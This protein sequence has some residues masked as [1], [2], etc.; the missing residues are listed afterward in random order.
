MPT[1]DDNRVL[2]TGGARGIGA[3]IAQR[4][5]DDGYTPVILDRYGDDPEIVHCDLSGTASTADALRRV[6]VDGPITRIVNN[7]GA[8]FPHTLEEQTLDEFDRAAALNLRSAFQ[9]TQALIPGMT[10]RNFGRIVSVSSRAALGKTART[11][12]AATKAGLLGATRVWALELGQHGITANAVAPGPIATEL[13]ADANPADA[14]KTRQIIDGI[15]VGRMGTPDDVAHS[16][17]FFLDD[18]SGFT[19]GQTSHVCGGLTVGV[20][21]V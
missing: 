12:Y 16:V 3:A 11:A 13:F 20:A 17:S 10:G 21:D 15:P 14:P 5:R 4:C 6:L 8:V 2:I 1:H 9:C 19:T 18:R 7:V